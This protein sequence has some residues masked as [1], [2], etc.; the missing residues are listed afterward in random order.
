VD[1]ELR[2][3]GLDA[4]VAGDV[5]LPAGVDADHADVLDAGLGA[6]A[7]AARHRELDLVRRVHAPQRTLEVLAHLRAVLRAEAA[8]LA[9]DAGLHR[10]Q[11]FRI[12]VAARHAEVAPHVHQLLLLH[13]EQADALA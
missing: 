6:I 5:E 3:L 11:R 10:A 2:R 8:P 12:R 1:E 13:A 7:R 9:A 4:A